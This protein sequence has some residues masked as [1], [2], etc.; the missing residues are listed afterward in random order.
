MKF[1]ATK[2]SEFSLCLQ[3][4]QDLAELL[5]VAL[6]EGFCHLGG[7][8]CCTQVLPMSSSSNSPLSQCICGTINLSLLCFQVLFKVTLYIHAK[9]Q[10]LR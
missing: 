3:A 8:M 9:S 6:E 4:L 2:L 7:P 1:P 5:Y 10:Q